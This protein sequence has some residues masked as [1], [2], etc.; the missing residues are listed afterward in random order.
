MGSFV[1]YGNTSELLKMAPLN[2][3]KSNSQGVS[4]SLCVGPLS[5]EEK[6]ETG[7]S[8]LTPVACPGHGAPL[9]KGNSA[10]EGLGVARIFCYAQTI[11]LYIWLT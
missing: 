6:Y 1:S 5:A 3:F 11:F 2:I 9:I 7:M 4:K 8:H 10:I